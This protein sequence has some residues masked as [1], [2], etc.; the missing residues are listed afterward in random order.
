MTIWLH[1]YRQITYTQNS[2]SEAHIE[3]EKVI[4]F[5]LDF[6]LQFIIF[7]PEVH[8]IWSMR[9]PLWDEQ[10]TLLKKIKKYNQTKHNQTENLPRPLC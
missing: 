3:R 4:S 6:R 10:L 9:V 5:H 2:T 1:L 8:W 7:G